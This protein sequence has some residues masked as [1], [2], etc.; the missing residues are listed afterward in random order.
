ME[1]FIQDG[2]KIYPELSLSDLDVDSERSTALYKSAL[3]GIGKFMLLYTN[4]GHA[5]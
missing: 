2:R 3:Y 5:K 1:E 4:I